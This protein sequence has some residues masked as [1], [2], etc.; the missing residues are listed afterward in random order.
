MGRDWR[1]DTAELLDGGVEVVSV[2]GDDDH[3]EL[4]VGLSGGRVTTQDVSEMSFKYCS[5]APE[6]NSFVQQQSNDLQKN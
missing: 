5:S 6:G 2:A 4:Y 3:H 1:L